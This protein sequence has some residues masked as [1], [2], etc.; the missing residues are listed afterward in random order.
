M[1]Y[2]IDAESDSLLI[3]NHAQ[4]YYNVQNSRHKRKLDALET[5]LQGI[6]PNK[7]L[8]SL[9]NLQL[10]LSLIQKAFNNPNSVNSEINFEKAIEKLQSDIDN[11]LYY[12][13]GSPEHQYS[14][15][16]EAA[17]AN[18]V[19]PTQEELEL[20]NTEKN[21]LLGLLNNG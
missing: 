15:D 11:G 2:I 21:Q 13:E 19:W 4:E 16:Y 7:P 3:Q 17:K 14:L 1:E 6:F 8:P 10:K 5:Y 18:F 20:R 12:I 9:E